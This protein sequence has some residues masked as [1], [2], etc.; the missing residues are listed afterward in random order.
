MTLLHTLITHISK[1]VSSG[2]SYFP[3]GL[4]DLYDSKSLTK[5]YITFEHDRSNLF[6]NPC[7]P[8]LYPFYT[9]SLVTFNP[10][11]V[12]LIVLDISNVWLY[13]VSS[14]G[15]TERPNPSK[16][17]KKKKSFRS[18]R[19]TKGTRLNLRSGFSSLKCLTPF[20]DMECITRLL[21]V[22]VTYNILPSLP[23]YNHTFF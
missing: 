2:G 18:L 6:N 4:S 1:F 10:V 8:L 9:I 17:K 22:F 16:C 14:N 21:S 15:G 11:G 3:Y 5:V 7:I 23:L 19:Y 13:G 20:K 12:Y